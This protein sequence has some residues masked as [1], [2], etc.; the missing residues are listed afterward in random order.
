MS[1]SNRSARASRGWTDSLRALSIPLVLVML[2]ACGGGGGG[3]GGGGSGG[4]GGG[5]AGSNC[6]VTLS[7]TSLSWRVHEGA[8]APAAQTIRASATGFTG[9]LY[10][11]AFVEDTGG[12]QLIEPDIELL[13]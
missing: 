7:S 3:T 11:D 12:P 1:P 2:A 4:G 8:P 5:S 9:T 10:I 13:I 6:S